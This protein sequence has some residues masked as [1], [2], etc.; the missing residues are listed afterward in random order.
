MNNTAEQP[1]TETYDGGSPEA[2]LRGFKLL[3]QAILKIQEKNREIAAATRPMRTLHSK[4]ITGI[5]QAQLH[6]DPQLPVRFQVDYFRPGSLWKAVVRFSN[7]SGVPR[8]DHLPDMRGIAIKVELQNGGEHDL[9]MTNYPVSHARNARQ[10]VEFAV[11]AM[12]DSATFKTRLEEYFG[13]DETA[14]MLKTVTAGM[15]PSKGL[16]QE[17]F[18]SRGALLWGERPVRL[19]LRPKVDGTAARDVPATQDGLREAFAEQLSQRS[20]E[21]RLA[22]QPFVNE[23]LTPI[24]DAAIEWREDVSEPVEIATLVL[25]S[26]DIL[27]ERGMQQMEAVNGMAFNPWNAPAAFRPLGN[28]NRARAEVY[29]A[30]ARQWV[31]EPR[32]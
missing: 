20:I 19:L 7:A 13:S 22:I 8:A 23:S 16:D 17:A 30:S 32:C 28:I 3:A 10:F 31:A 5:S 24:E 29:G 2:E 21:Y 4:I 26:Q 27:G 18:W 1:W 14:R 25:P 12:G 11:I 6:I 15:R 9:L